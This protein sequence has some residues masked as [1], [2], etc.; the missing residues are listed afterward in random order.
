M[1]WAIA[2]RIL[3]QILL[4]IVSAE[5]GIST[6]SAKLHSRWLSIGRLYVDVFACAPVDLLLV[7]IASKLVNSSVI[8]IITI[9]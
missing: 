4:V 8:G 6:K 3:R 9:P 7:P 5:T 2:I 1:I